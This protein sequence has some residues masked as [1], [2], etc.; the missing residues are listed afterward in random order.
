MKRS[1]L[2]SRSKPLARR[3]AVKRKRATP[4][5]VS[6]DRNPEYL[7]WLRERQCVACA[8][9][10]NPML[11]EIMWPIIDAAHG[12]VNGRGSKGPDSGAIPLCRHHHIEQHQIGWQLFERKYGISREKEAAAHFALFHFDQ[13]NRCT[14]H[15]DAM[16]CPVHDP[17]GARD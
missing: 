15:L 8:R 4:R 12:P 11:M 6:V 14:C 10:C 2:P 5:R 3:T 16:C 9:S 1:P 13:A 7:A 17:Q